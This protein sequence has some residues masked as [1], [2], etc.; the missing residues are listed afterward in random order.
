MQPRIAKLNGPVIDS[1]PTSDEVRASRSFLRGHIYNRAG[2][3]ISP[4]RFAAAAKETKSSFSDLLGVIARSYAG[5]QGQ[6]EQRQTDI[7]SAART[8]S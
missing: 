6:T 8:G 2:S 7:S 5:G 3:E 4:R 1:M